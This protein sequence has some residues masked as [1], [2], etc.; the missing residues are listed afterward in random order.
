[1]F[2]LVTYD[3]KDDKR[4][5]KVCNILKDY[6]NRLQYSVFECKLNKKL[7]EQMIKRALKYINNSEDSL[8]IYFLCNECKKKIVF[9]GIGKIDDEDENIIIF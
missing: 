1:M 3:I 4:R 2:V 5:N 8:R 7:Y 6:G 9:Y